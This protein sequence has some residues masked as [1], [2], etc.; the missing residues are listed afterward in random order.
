[1]LQRLL[2]AVASLQARSEEHS[3]LSVE[4]EQR[5]MEAEERHKLVKE[6]HI[7]AIRMVEEREGELLKA[8]VEKPT[9]SM[10][11]LAAQPFSEEINRKPIPQNFW[12]VV[13]EPFD[14]TRDP[15]LTFKPFKP[16]CTL[17]EERTN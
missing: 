15:I 12:E 9:R 16:K 5:Q 11:S 17:A 6:R 1:M 4:A 14:G 13:I 2:Q 7:E 3:R 8:I 10:A